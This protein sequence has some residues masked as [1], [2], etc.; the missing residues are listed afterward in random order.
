MCVDATSFF[1]KSSTEGVTYFGAPNSP[2]DFRTGLS[3]TGAV[4]VTSLSVAPLSIAAL[5]PALG[6]AWGAVGRSRE[7][8]TA[9]ELL[10]MLRGC[11]K[12]VSGWLSVFYRAMIAPGFQ[13]VWGSCTISIVI[14]SI[15]SSNGMKLLMR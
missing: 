1:Y 14:A 6:A 4:S 15:T 7:G 2:V 9:A 12:T 8:V 11:G 5:A 13:R 3:A 10:K